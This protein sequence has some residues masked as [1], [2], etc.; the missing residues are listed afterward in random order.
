MTPRSCSRSSFTPVAYRRTGLGARTRPAGAMRLGHVSVGASASAS[1][2][3]TQ[4]DVTE[5]L[6]AA[7]DSHS[8]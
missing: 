4:P 7:P 3:T 6:R 1:P 2:T 5:G 8:M